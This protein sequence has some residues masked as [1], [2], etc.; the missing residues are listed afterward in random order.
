MMSNFLFR[1][2]KHPK[3]QTKVLNV[4]S[5]L[6]IVNGK[7]EHGMGGRILIPHNPRVHPGGNQNGRFETPRTLGGNETE[8]IVAL[9]VLLF[10]FV[11]VFD[12]GEA[13]FVEVLFD[14]G[15][16][17]VGDVAWLG[18]AVEVGRDEIVGFHAADY[19]GQAEWEFV[20]GGGGEGTSGCSPRCLCGDSSKSIGEHG[21]GYGAI[22][23]AI[24]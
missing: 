20:I 7:P 23:W 19:F 18:F 2:V 12:G 11:E 17:E 21:D 16:G 3:E 22:N 24:G 13:E 15:C 6:I 4:V 5:I 14:F 8:F 9:H 10:H 1:N